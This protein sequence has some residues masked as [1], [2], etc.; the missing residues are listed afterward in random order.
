MLRV[1]YN[2][3]KTSIKNAIKDE[4]SLCIKLGD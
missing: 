1:I 4:S 3:L 2:Y